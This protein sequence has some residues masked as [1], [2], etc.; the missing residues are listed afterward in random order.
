MKR[1]FLTVAVIATMAI[2]SSSAVSAQ[3]PVQTTTEQPADQFATIE[4]S[5]LPEAVT[6]AVAKE[7]E[8]STIKEAFENK[9]AKLY[10]VVVVATDATE[11]TV[12]YNEN[13]EAQK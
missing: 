9:E 10:K 6:V 11:T 2:A 13:G 3:E 4:V 7:Y 5:A 8:G 1:V 12:I